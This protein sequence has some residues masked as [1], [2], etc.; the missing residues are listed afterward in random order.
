MKF[1][2]LFSLKQILFALFLFALLIPIALWDS[3]T[4]VKTEFLQ[5]SVVIRSDKFRMS[6]EYAQ[7][8]SAELA[9]LAEAGEATQEPWTDNDILRT[10]Y[11][12]NDIWGDYCIVADLDADTC[13]VLH[14]KDGRTFVFSA[15]SNQEN[16]ELYEM[17]LTHLEA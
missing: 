16:T 7:I 3:A 6:V 14:L 17:L 4:Q 9:P 2:N 12:H 15:N 1:R 10:G 8:D 5:E 13:V 11:W